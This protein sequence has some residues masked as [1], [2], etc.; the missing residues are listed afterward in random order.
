MHLALEEK[1]G[2]GLSSKPGQK[3]W[4]FKGMEFKSLLCYVCGVLFVFRENWEEEGEDGTEMDLWFFS[5]IGR[6]K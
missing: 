5:Q 2:K 4:V 1:P 3:V 6:R